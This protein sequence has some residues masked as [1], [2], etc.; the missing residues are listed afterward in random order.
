MKKSVSLPAVP[1]TAELMEEIFPSPLGAMTDT[2]LCKL[3]EYVC[4]Y[5]SSF[6]SGVEPAISSWTVV[7]IEGY[8]FLIPPVGAYRVQC[9][10]NYYTGT[11]DHYTY[12]VSLTLVVFN[13]RLW[14]FS[15]LELTNAQLKS[16]GHLSDRYYGML[17]VAYEC[18]LVSSTELARFLD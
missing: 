10:N 17:R 18:P 3:V 1:I 2:D 7:S 11:M 4:R 15:P 5:N 8:K 13:H 12:G 16:A 6:I 14:E 9:E